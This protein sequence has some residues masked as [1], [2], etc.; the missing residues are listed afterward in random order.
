[1]LMLLSKIQINLVVFVYIII[2]IKKIEE[3]EKIIKG[4]NKNLLK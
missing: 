3:N 4:N 1:M 2:L